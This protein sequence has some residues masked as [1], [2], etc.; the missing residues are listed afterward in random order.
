MFIVVEKALDVAQNAKEHMWTQQK[1]Y[2]FFVFW[3]KKTENA[4]KALDIQQNVRGHS[5]ERNKVFIF[6]RF[7]KQKF[8]TIEKALATKQNWRC[9]KWSVRR[10]MH[11]FQHAHESCES[12]RKIK[13]LAAGKRFQQAQLAQNH[14]FTNVWAPS[15][16]C[17]KWMDPDGVKGHK[18][19]T[20][21]TFKNMIDIN[22]NNVFKQDLVTK[23]IICVTFGERPKSIEFGLPHHAFMRLSIFATGPERNE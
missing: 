8:K 7:L 13:N 16:K 14:Y 22:K 23:T 4:E 15:R 6:V 5:S 9:S 12:Q 18:P 1:V 11:G 21:K 19:R 20:Q 17:I 2:I 3:N 10:L